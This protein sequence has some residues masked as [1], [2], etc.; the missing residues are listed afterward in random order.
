MFA[1]VAHGVRGLHVLP[2]RRATTT[3]RQARIVGYRHPRQPQNGSTARPQ[4]MAQFHV[5]PVHE[6]ALVQRADGLE[7]REP[8]Q[9]AGAGEKLHGFWASIRLGRHRAVSPK[10]HDVGK[11][12]EVPTLRPHPAVR[13]QHCGAHRHHTR[14]VAKDFGHRCQEAMW[15]A[16]VVVEQQ[17]LLGAVLRGPGDAPVHR[18]AVAEILLERQHLCGTRLAAQ[19]FR[20]TVPGAVVHQQDQ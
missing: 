20:G 13:P 14:V 5:L 10:A 4:P 16:H 9:A 8:E 18:R 2:Q 15:Q 7:I 11:E 1:Q 6:V 12:A 17:H 19:A 3:R